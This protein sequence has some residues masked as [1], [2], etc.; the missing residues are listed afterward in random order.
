[1]RGSC[2]AMRSSKFVKMQPMKRNASFV[3]RPAYL[4]ATAAAVIAASCIAIVRTEAFAGNR[5]VIAWGVTMDLMLTIP[6]LY[7]LVIVRMH[8]ARPMTIVPVFAGCAVLATLVLPRGY[9]QTEHALRLVVAPIEALLI[10]LVVRK[11]VAM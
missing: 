10:I 4:F 3:Q 6:L 8:V 7:Y 5:D 9:Q 2:D 11:L 1:M